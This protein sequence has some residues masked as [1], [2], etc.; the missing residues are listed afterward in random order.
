MIQ[1]NVLYSIQDNFRKALNNNDRKEDMKMANVNTRIFKSLNESEYKE[2]YTPKRTLTEATTDVNE[3]AEEYKEAYHIDLDLKRVPCVIA[4]DKFLSGWGGAEGKTHY[5]VVLCGDSTEA[6]NIESSMRGCAAQEGLSNIRRDF[7]VHL[8]SRVSASYVVGRYAP[9]WNNLSDS[10]YEN[11][12]DSGKTED[13]INQEKDVQE[14]RRQEKLR[15]KEQQT[16]ESEK[17]KES[18]NDFN[19]KFN[20]EATIVQGNIE[21]AKETLKNLITGINS[22]NIKEITA[23]VSESENLQEEYSEK[24]GGEPEDFISD[25]EII[26]TKL[27]EIDINT[28][29]THLAQEIVDQFISTCDSQISMAK[30]RF[31]GESKEK[32]LK[33]DEENIVKMKECTDDIEVITA[34]EGDTLELDDMEDWNRLKELA[35]SLASSQGFYGRLLA[36]MKE[37]NEE[38][39]EFPIYL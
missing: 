15:Q 19:L 3:V 6:S 38:D 23:N 18:P 31:L 1:S 34:L 26:K 29:G 20:G 33:E 21:A 16:N 5:Q 17:L 32:E 25:V 14:E 22:S 13:E 7:G 11:R 2:L 9:A 37:V 10:W 30:S 39:L 4:R 8:S 36:N 12:F 24:L 28:L 27:A 35:N